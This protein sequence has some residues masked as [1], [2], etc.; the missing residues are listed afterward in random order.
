MTRIRRG[1]ITSRVRRK[2][3]Q[4][5]KGF[6]GAWSTLSRPMMQGSLRALNFSY[7]HRKKRQNAFRRLSILR[8]NA[9]IRSCGLP[10]TYNKLI[11]ALRIYK[12][13]LN[14]NVLNQL[15]VRDSATF[16]QL[17]SFYSH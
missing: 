17:M 15:G 1:K 12:C 9:V 11:S 13:R 5:S 8:S 16:V 4:S 3:I 10:I 7:K 6:R 2:R 14:R